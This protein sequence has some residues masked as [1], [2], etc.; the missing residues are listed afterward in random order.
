MSPHTQT[1]IHVLWFGVMLKGDKYTHTH[2]Q[3]LTSKLQYSFPVFHLLLCSGPCLV[4]RLFFS[5]QTASPSYLSLS[6]IKSLNMHLTKKKS[7]NKI[8]S[9][10]YV[11]GKVNIIS[12]YSVFCW[13]QPP[14][15]ISQLAIHYRYLPPLGIGTC[16]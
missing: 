7:R 8:L 14:S 16:H 5:F 11:C 1:Y 3:L 13:S 9:I 10:L 15:V 12:M 4:P 2:C 6:L